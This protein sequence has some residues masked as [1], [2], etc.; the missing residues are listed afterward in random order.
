[1]LLPSYFALSLSHYPCL[2]PFAF[3]P[4]LLL[5]FSRTIWARLETPAGYQEVSKPHGNPYFT[6]YRRRHSQNCKRTPCS[7]KPA[8]SHR[9]PPLSRG[10]LSL[11]APLALRHSTGFVCMW[12]NWKVWKRKQKQYNPR[13]RPG[14][15]E[16]ATDCLPFGRTGN[17]LNSLC[18]QCTLGTALSALVRDPSASVRPPFG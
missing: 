8:P 10:P 13:K 16:W 12:G 7:T 15:A 3:C 11:L 6:L 9:W 18:A 17:S 4:T 5:F 14:C 1:M 2:C